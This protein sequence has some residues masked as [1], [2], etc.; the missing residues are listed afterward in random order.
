MN[1]VKVGTAVGLS[2]VRYISALFS[3]IVAKQHAC[4]IDQQTHII[5]K[6]SIE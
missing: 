2:E 1:V 4:L 5:S 3:Y 6:P